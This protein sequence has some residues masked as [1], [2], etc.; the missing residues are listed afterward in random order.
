M[1]LVMSTQAYKEEPSVISSLM[2]KCSLAAYSLSERQKQL[3]LKPNVR[4]LYKLK[5]KF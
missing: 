1:R 5:N 2:E 3:G 4:D